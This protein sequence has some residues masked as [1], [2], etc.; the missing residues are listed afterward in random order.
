[1]RFAFLAASGA[2]ALMIA[3]PAFADTGN[4]TD[5]Q[6][7]GTVASQCGIGHQ[8]GT[9]TRGQPEVVTIP[10]LVDANGQVD[11]NNSM[12][13]G[14]DNIW[15][16]GPTN[17]ITIAVTSL[18]LQNPPA[19]FDASSFEDYLDI[20]L[21][22]DG[23][24]HVLSYLGL[25]NISSGSGGATTTVTSAI[26]AFET[27]TQDYSQAKLN[28]SVPSPHNSGDRPLAGTYK[29]TVTITVAAS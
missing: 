5:I 26:G 25:S 29:G 15:C 12:V 17:H 23:T 3:A 22:D 16:N 2:A 1:M 27:G 28:Y 10:S 6:I 24:D 18:Q 7:T 4:S 8:S 9:G 20:N 19:S 21:T 11:P 13:V 14:F